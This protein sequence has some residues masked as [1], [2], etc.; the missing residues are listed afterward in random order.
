MFG[1][2]PVHL[3]VIFLVALLIFG[4]KRLPEMGRSIGKMINEFRHSTREMTDVFREGINN[5]GDAGTTNNIAP[6]KT[7]LSAPGISVPI[8]TPSIA[9]A[10]SGNFCIQCGAPNTPEARFC[11]QCGTKLLIKTI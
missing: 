3:L 1:I 11:N 9:S 8:R 4:P 2:Q 6:L 7:P 5:P 10:R